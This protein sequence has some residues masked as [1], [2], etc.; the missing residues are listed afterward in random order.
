MFPVLICWTYEYDEWIKFCLNQ[1]AELCLLWRLVHSTLAAL[2]NFV[3]ATY[4]FATPNT[5]LQLKK[6]K[7]AF[8]I[9]LCSSQ[10]K[11]SF[12]TAK[13]ARGAKISRLLFC[14]SNSFVAGEEETKNKKMKQEAVLSLQSWFYRKGTAFLELQK[15]ISSWFQRL[16]YCIQLHQDE[17]VRVK[18][19]PQTAHM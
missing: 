7:R 15:L 11:R 14:T 8:C 5:D 9:D 17:T 4:T 16:V 3:A 19:S 12:G 6:K 1:W 18:L 13:A 2:Q 10:S